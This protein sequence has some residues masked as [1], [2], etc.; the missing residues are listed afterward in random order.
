MAS[1]S[2]CRCPLLGRVRLWVLA[3]LAG[4]VVAAWAPR[5]GAAQTT[6]FKL[7]QSKS[8]RCRLPFTLQRNLIVVPVML[9]GRGPY[10]FMLDTGVGTSLITDPGLRDSLDLRLGQRFL[11]AGVGE[12]APLVAFQTDSVRVQLGDKASSPSISFLLLS[13]DVFDLSSYVGQPIHGILGAD[14]FRSFVVEVDAEEQVLILHDPT[15]FRAP[16]GRRW[17]HLPLDIEGDKSYINTEVALNDSVRMP[18]KLILDTGAGHA[19]SIETS[20]DARLTLPPK[21]LRTHLGR[22]LSG[23]VHGYLGRVQGLQLGRYYVN[24]LITSFPDDKAVQAKVNVPRNGNVGFE[25]LKRFNVIIDYPHNKLWL[26]PN[27]LYRD[28][29]EHDMCGLELLATG[30]QY[31]RYVVQRVEP[32]SPADNANIKPRDEIL[33]LNLAPAESFSLTQLSRLLHS[34]DGRELILFLRR[35]DGE[36]YVARITLKRQI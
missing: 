18:L 23:D 2:P 29:F 8:T 3:W 30:P 19:L 5:A 17:T 24:S 26:K 15:R 35:P 4:V 1:S 22:G 21:R 28:P 31:R 36:I 25:L 14:V 10:Y 33:S 7:T 6:L 16:R 13:D 12:E 20:S 34:A 11:V 27:G 32:G 9:N